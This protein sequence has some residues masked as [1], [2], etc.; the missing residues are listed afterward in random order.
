[1]FLI[2]ANLRKI[3]LSLM[4][5]NPFIRENVKALKKVSS[6]CFI[7]AGCY[8]CNMVINSNFKDFNF[9]YVDDKGIHTD[10]EFIIFL[11]AGCFILILAKVF[12]QA[13]E[14]KEE[15]DFTI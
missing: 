15:N 6:E 8:I 14:Y 2:V 10:M 9:I 3:L 13:V 1:M 4:K 7:I 5:A 12:Q 11:F